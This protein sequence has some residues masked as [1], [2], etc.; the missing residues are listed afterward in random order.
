MTT[1]KA[2]W[3][4]TGHTVPGKPG[5]AARLKNLLLP[6]L[7][8]PLIAACGTTADGPRDLRVAET[9]RPEF[10]LAGNDGGA[11][12]ALRFSQDDV[13]LRWWEGLQDAR[14]GELV[15]AAL[16]HN[17][18]VGI[19]LANLEAAR[20]SLREQALARRPGLQ[21]DLSAGDQRLSERAAGPAAGS[22]FNSYE[23]GFD[24]AWELDLFDRIAHQTEAARAAMEASSAELDQIYVTVA[25][26]VARN[27]VQLRGAQ[28]RLDVNQRHARNLE[29]SY[30]L[31]LDL[32]EGG[33]GDA[34]D[35][36][37]ALS[38][39][40]RV[41][42]NTP[43][44]RAE[45]DAAINR[46]SVLTGQMPASLRDILAAP[47]A[48]PSIPPSVAIGDPAELL[49][50]RPDIRRAEQELAGAIARYDMSVSELYPRI[51]ISGSIGY[52]ATTFA[53][54]G[55]GGTLGH[56]IG[57]SLSW[58][59]FDR[60]RPRARV[61][62]ADAQ[63]Q[64]RLQA[65]EKTL[66][67]AFEELDNAISALRWE[68]ERQAS[69]LAAAQAS[70]LA[71]E[72]ARERFDAGADSFLD[73]LDAQ[74]TSLQAEEDLADSEIRLAVNLIALYKA[75]GGGWEVARC[76]ISGCP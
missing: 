19:A 25:A 41:N 6:P 16:A 1:M 42:A 45:I 64:A 50:R 71:L 11:S 5:F 65:F 17:R 44:L 24:V 39:H 21:A 57:P 47:A 40:E 3:G 46:L 59:A 68:G 74:R 55:S 73:V 8:L 2:R 12:A 35:V 49:R 20:S 14:L 32:M 54:L 63:V 61:A 28:H 72:L 66:L 70:T 58:E 37:R 29:Q 36:Q 48:L 53:D 38:L 51:S 34:L 75:L 62:A 69:L 30:R 15:E 18:D 13:V 9:I 27:Y 4:R 33:L 76:E 22:R 60:A 67:L 52:L 10:Q 7:L 23:T 31:T 26:E 43:P 56:F